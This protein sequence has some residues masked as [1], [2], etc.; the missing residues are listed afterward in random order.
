MGCAGKWLDD[1]MGWVAIARFVCDLS[2][3]VISIATPAHTARSVYTWAGPAK[4]L[5]D[6]MRLVAIVR[7][8]QAWARPAK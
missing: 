8:V 2:L 5:D 1:W 6:W 7:F 3:L 4:T